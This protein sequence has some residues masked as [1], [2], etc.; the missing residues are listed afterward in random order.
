MWY[1]ARKHC[2]PSI[3][4]FIFTDLSVSV[5]AHVCVLYWLLQWQAKNQTGRVCVSSGFL[6]TRLADQN[7][8]MVWRVCSRWVFAV[9][10]V[11]PT[12]VACTT[13]LLSWCCEREK[14][15]QNCC[16]GWELLSL[17]SPSCGPRLENLFLI[18]ACPCD[19]VSVACFASVNSKKRHQCFSQSRG[20]Q[21]NFTHE[22]KLCSSESTSDMVRGATVSGLGNPHLTTG[23]SKCSVH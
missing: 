7:E 6:S 18:A 11:L 17:H 15:P 8:P 14:N 5:C 19:L 21:L 12:S 2:D 13:T 20:R 22:S 23:V 3:H 4:D 9:A 10:V 1:L 16:A